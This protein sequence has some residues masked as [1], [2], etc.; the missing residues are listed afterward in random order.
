M[1]SAQ[2]PQSSFS[3]PAGSGQRM[4]ILVANSKGGCGKTTI[5]TNLACYYAALGRP[6]TLLDLD[7]QQ[8]ALQWL[9]LRPNDDIHG[10]SWPNGEPLSLGRLQQRLD[11]A[12]ELVIIDS[13][14]GLDT[15]QL[16]HLLRLSQIVLVPVLPSP[17]DIRATTRFLQSVML[18]PSYRRR[19]R[20]LAVIANR[21][22]TRTKMYESLRQFLSSLKIPYLVTLRD[23]QLYVQAMASG[24]GIMDVAV[25]RNVED[26]RHWRIIGEWLEV[27]RHLIRALPGFR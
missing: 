13:P 26:Q 15:H 14:A 21:A 6:V 10:L 1:T 27:Q 17:I 9:K 24:E 4:V 18:T 12:G 2:N 22:R 5:A 16:D 7:P 20:R 3:R 8:S 23:T 19:P 11:H 25:S